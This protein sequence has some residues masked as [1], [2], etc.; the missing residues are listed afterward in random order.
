[1]QG[2]PNNL[3][4]LENILNA[5]SMDVTDLPDV[6]QIIS[7]KERNGTPSQCSPKP[8]EV[9]NEDENRTVQDVPDA[10][11]NE[12]SDHKSISGHKG[13]KQLSGQKSNQ[14]RNHGPRRAALKRNV[15]SDGKNKKNK[16]TGLANISD[17]KFSQRKPIKTRLISEL[18]DSQ[19][20]GS[21]DAIEADNA[22]TGD[23]CESHKSK[24]PLEVG[25][26]DDTPVS[27]QKV[28]DFQSVAV[29]NKAKLRGA[30]NVD[31]RS[32]LMNWLRK[33]HKKVRK[34]KRG[35]GHKNCDSSAVSNSNPDI[36]ASTDMQH[37]SIP[38]GDLGQENVLS[39]N[40]GK[41]ENENAQ[42]MQKADDLC[43]NESEN[44]KQRFLSNGKST[45][46]LKRKVLLPATSCGDNTENSSIKRSALRTD[47]L[48]QMESEGTVQ[49]CLTK[50]RS[51]IISCFWICS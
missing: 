26:D 4:V 30:E 13:S 29:K 45:I 47:D 7:S 23:I 12:S 48:R 37:G 49:R 18:I 43:Q 44:L 51:R 1:M 39:T 50:V 40:S 15:G 6:P 20:G 3:D 38:V 28:C 22:K 14:V 31:D 8:C 11:Q 17:L 32:S 27:N 35:S 36:P 25:K 19:I 34:E 16:S 2:S 10:D 21:T 33:T 42:N 5:V 46:L 24:M 9:P 41:H